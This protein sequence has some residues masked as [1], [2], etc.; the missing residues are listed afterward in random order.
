[1]CVV[2]CMSLGIKCSQAIVSDCI[3]EALCVFCTR[4]V[5]SYCFN[6]FNNLNFYLNIYLRVQLWHEMWNLLEPA[7][8][9]YVERYRVF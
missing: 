8:L 9:S 2:S 5:Q 6:N 3:P 1:M 7:K 4:M